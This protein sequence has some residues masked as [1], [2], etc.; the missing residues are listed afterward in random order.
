MMSKTIKTVSATEDYP[1]DWSFNATEDYPDHWSYNATED[2][3][4]HWSYNAQHEWFK[5]YPDCGQRSQ[6]PVNLP[7]KGFIKAKTPRK[8]IFGNYN[9]HPQKFS[10]NNDGQRV[11]FK[12]EWK[13][14]RQPYIYGG[15]GHSRRYTF[16]SITLH[17]PSEHSVEGIMYPIE[18]QVL[19]VSADY[20]TLEEAMKAS[21]RDPL[22]FL[23][24]VNL[25]MFSNYTHEGLSS[26]LKAAKL[27]NHSNSD[28]ALNPL[29][30]YNPPFKEYACYQG[31]LTVPPC[32]ESV[33][34]LVRA[35]ALSVTRNA[36]DS[37]PVRSAQGPMFS[38]L[39]QPL[40]DRKVY[41]F[42]H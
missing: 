15:A 14:D 24:I 23:G 1:D 27:S 8:L 37:F 7:Y 17:W 11:T 30:Y 16:H 2:Y 12:G 18:S 25:Y 39:V 22:A 32:T 36:L 34:W 21:A 19:H 28:M 3:A 29:Q 41:Y 4:K 13:Y 31:S 40:N 5:T 9:E 20:K 33:L 26:M 42:K 10:V 38:R 35:H 6:S